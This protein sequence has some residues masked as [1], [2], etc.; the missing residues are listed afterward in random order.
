MRTIPQVI[1]Q[2]KSDAG[3]TAIVGDKVFADYPPQGIEEP[4][5]IASTTS[6]IAHGTV[7]NCVIRAYSS[8]MEIDSAATSRSQAEQLS[9]AVE[10]A[11]D[12]FTSLTD[13]THPIQGVTL[14]GGIE[15][16]LL[17]PNDGSDERLFICSQDFQIH[18]RRT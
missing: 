11:I 16:Q 1:A 15:W 7:S 5:V 17:S 2:L 12:G 10:D 14:D 18:Y 13:T 6:G 9:E 3:V 8:R 4:Y